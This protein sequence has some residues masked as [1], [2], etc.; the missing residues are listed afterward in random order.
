M[1]FDI[2]K[3]LT[4]NLVSVEVEIPVP[5]LSMFS[6]SPGV[7]PTWKVR[8]LTGHELFKVNEAVALNRDL[9]RLVDELASGATEAK[10]NAFKETLGITDKSTDDFVRRLAMLTFGTVEPVIRLEGVVRLADAYPMT[11]LVLSNR[12]LE[13]TGEGKRL[14]E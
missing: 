14:G 9:S 12:V 3:F 6:V 5:E 10:I 1:G 2:Q 7:S 8:G 11:F 13:L 4:C